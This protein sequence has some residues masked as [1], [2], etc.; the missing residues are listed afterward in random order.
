ML[1]SKFE[2]LKM[3][4][5]ESI[6]NFNSKLCNIANETFTLNE[7]YPKIKLVK[8]NFEITTIKICLQS[9]CY[10]GSKKCKHNEVGWINQ[11]FELNPKQSKKEKTI[12]FRVEEKDSTEEGK[13]SDVESLILLTKNFNRFLQKMNRKKNA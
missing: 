6:S 12:T 7:K 3:L 10:W 13:S 8:K 11:T 9:G 1:A 5:D 4:E 2:D